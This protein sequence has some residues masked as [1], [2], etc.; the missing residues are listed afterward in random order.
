MIALALNLDED[1]FEKVGALSGPVGFM[2]LLHYPGLI[3][4]FRSS[5]FSQI[6]MRIENSYTRQ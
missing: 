4:L 5:V 1:F 2:R 3:A 6:I